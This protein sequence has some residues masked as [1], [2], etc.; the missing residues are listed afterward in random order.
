MLLSPQPTVTD[1]DRPRVRIDLD[2]GE[3]FEFVS[4]QVVRNGSPIRS[5]PAITGLRE[6]HC[7]DYEAP[8]GSPASYSA[9]GAVTSGWATVHA[10]TWADLSDW[11]QFDSASVSGGQLATGTVKRSDITFPTS[12]RL[13]LD[14]PPSGSGAVTFGPLTMYR[15]GSMIALAS[16][17][18][19][20]TIL[21]SSGPVTVQWSEST[22]TMT[23]DGV[24]VS[25]TF[26]QPN[27]DPYPLAVSA[28]SPG[29][30]IQIPDP[31]AAVTYSESASTVLDEPRAWLIH[32]SQP[33]LSV[34]IDAGVGN[35]AGQGLGTMR[36]S[37]QDTTYAANRSV[38][39]PDGRDQAVAYPLGP[40]LRGEYALELA[41][42]TLYARDSVL[43][44]A[45]DQTP[46]LMR[47]PTDWEWDIPD[48]WYSVGDIS[49]ARATKNRD[50][51]RR[52]ITL[53]M[54]RTPEP[55]VELAPPMTW[56]DLILRGITW[57]QLTSH[58]WLDVLMGEV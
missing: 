46:L 23:H 17:F 4:L 42:F 37:A 7:F 41:S 50:D 14:E 21:A 28:I 29:F 35:W 54:L 5:Q 9:V 56:G 31:L 51:P 3:G 39:Q 13:V 18:T 53:P 30:D 6:T 55:P 33:S 10:E 32:P 1:V 15:T 26:S 45:S 52:R 22:A 43:A 34:C 36:T 11:T 16:W 12:G 57:R 27:L 47:S 58:T 49:S 48:G 44:I 24:S 20:Q 25:V 2:A 19:V 40:R 8:F 38:F